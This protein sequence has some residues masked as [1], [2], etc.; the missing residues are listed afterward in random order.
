MHAD[1]EASQ[2]LQLNRVVR[3]L[4]AWALAIG[5]TIGWASFVMP[6]STY[7]P[8]AGPVGTAIA[9]CL[10]V[11]AMLVIAI[12]YGYMAQ[13]CPK[14]GG[15]YVYAREEFGANQAFV[16]SWCLVLAYCAA[17]CANVTAL[18][19]VIRSMFGNNLLMGPHYVIA[20]YDV[21]LSEVCL[22]LLTILAA[23]LV[24][25][26]G[27]GVTALVE[28]LLSVGMV[29]GVGG[30]ALLALTNPQISL[31][32]A[33]PAFSPH[34]T[35]LVGTLMVVATVPWAFIGFEAVSQVSAE[36]SFPQTKFARLMALA[37]VMAGV[38]YV[39]LNTVT[40]AVIPAGYDSW[41][42]YL[43]D[44]PNRSDITAIPSFIAGYQM[45]G[46]AGLWLFGI[47]ALCAV[48]SG[49]MGF[50]VASTRLIYT[51]AS[52]GALS[53]RLAHLHPSHH[54][55]TAAMSIVL[56]VTLV[57]PFLGRNVLSWVTDL[58]SLGALIA[59]LFT[60]RATMQQAA[61]RNDQL[62]RT[63]GMAGMALAVMGVAL[64]VVPIP[65]LGT[66]LS[67]ESYIILFAWVALG[68]NYFTPSAIR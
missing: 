59:Y 2:G 68:V 31:Q 57:V 48:L 23:T 26:R 39:V 24:L 16:C 15:V 4:G 22:C 37:I 40:A 67:K 14:D 6:S 8:K 62:M 30:I 41:T 34:A 61:R 54:T 55:P 58:M 7:L 11:V 44:L 28:T 42:T 38:M 3:P 56:A 51:M 18:P 12:N 65:Q 36:C 64:L 13:C 9:F 5:C 21:Y 49:V 47:T 25:Q 33:Q 19:L 20:G 10:G 43:A 60:S 46:Q 52:D 1:E 35:P 32:T 17:C 53:R 66:S 27:T 45:A 29:A 63:M 50:F